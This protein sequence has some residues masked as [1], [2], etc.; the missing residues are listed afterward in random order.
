MKNIKQHFRKQAKAILKKRSPFWL[1]DKKLYVQIRNLLIRHN[2]RQILV[3]MP[4]GH[5]VDILPLIYRLRRKH[6]IF[7]PAIQEL[8]FKMIPFRMPFFKNQYGIYEASKSR[9]KLIKVDTVIIPVLGIDKDFRRI[10]FGKGMYDRFFPSLKHKVRVVFVAR[11][12]N[13]A[14]NIITQSHDVQG[15]YFF[16]PSA[17]CVRKQNGSMVCDRKYN[18][19]IIG[20]HHGISC[21]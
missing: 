14:E 17:L 11:S 21:E 16:T 15:D 20:G 2:A 8:S 12:L 13:L 19:R 7:I 6:R 3:Y 18:I 10:G 9:L 4:F 1:L 5:E